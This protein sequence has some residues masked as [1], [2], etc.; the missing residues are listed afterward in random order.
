M[1]INQF[2]RTL[3]ARYRIILGVVFGLLLLLLA[4]I[5][6]FPAK[7]TATASVV[8]SS[9]T[10]DPLAGTTLQTPLTDNIVVTQLDIISSQRVARSVV[11]KLGLVNDPTLEE[12]WRSDTDGRGDIVDWIADRLLVPLKPK[13]GR[14]SNVIEIN[15]TST[16]AQFA[17]QAANAFTQAY[18]ETSSELKIEP[19]R[20]SAK[21][22]DVRIGELRGQLER[23]QAALSQGEKDV[24]IV[25]TPERIDVEN[26]RLNDLS[27]Q[28]A[29]AQSAQADSTSRSK[30][31]AGNVAGSPDVI[32]NG[33]VQQLKT[34]IAIAE[35]KLKEQSATQG[36][37]N[38]QYLAAQQELDNL[39]ASLAHESAQVG[40]SL[41]TASRVGADRSA[42]LQAAVETQ[43]QRI[44]DL[45]EKKNRLSVLQK[46]VDNADKAYQLVMERFAQTSIESHVAQPDVS[47]LAIA[48]EPTDP[49][50]PRI[51]LYLVLTLIFGFAVG[52]GVALLMEIFDPKVHGSMDVSVAIGLPVFAVVPALKS[53]RARIVG[54]L[55]NLRR[56][57]N[58][59]EAKLPSLRNS[60]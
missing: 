47:L 51:K 59:T 53:K 1:T 19:A 27:S 11:T 12:D 49:S 4:V 37:N 18:L 42:D 20:Q 8:V 21:F 44:I 13:T 40:S 30:G 38:P 55:D 5:L 10:E 14:G 56:G 28:L 48:G 17:K 16:N 3:S 26:A 25:V 22:F 24:G 45:S 58:A 9:Q 50:F 39:R 43:R 41:S 6:V 57:K 35:S 31:A 23:A 60:K 54:W 29:L 32:Q 34:Q 7:Y 46:E 33:V 52:I 15:Y 2:L 36:P